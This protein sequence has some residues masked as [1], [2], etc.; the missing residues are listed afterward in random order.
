MRVNYSPILSYIND[1]LER[2]DSINSLAKAAGLNRAS[3]DRLLKRKQHYLSNKNFLKL[4]SYWCQRQ[5]N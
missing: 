2:G 4:I 3:L 1:L 5:L